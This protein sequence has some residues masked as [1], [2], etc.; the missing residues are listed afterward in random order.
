M[1]YILST[2]ILTIVIFIIYVAVSI[3]TKNKQNNYQNMMGIMYLKKRFNLPLE[4]QNCRLIAYLLILLNSAIMALTSIIVFT[5][6]LS[7]FITLPIGFVLMYG[8]IYSLYGIIG[9]GLKGRNLKNG[10]NKKD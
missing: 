2:T 3:F 7:Y 1:E 8:L 9:N 6:N 5:I 4:K 10:K